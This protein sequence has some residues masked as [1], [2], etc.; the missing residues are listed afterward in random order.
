M[1]DKPTPHIS[2]INWR[3]KTAWPLCPH[4]YYI[5]PSQHCPWCAG[6]DTGGYKE[7]VGT[8]NGWLLKKDTKPCDDCGGPNIAGFG[9]FDGTREE[10]ELCVNNISYCYTCSMA[11]RY[12]T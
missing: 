6:V 2:E 4:G 8:G 9:A 5:T 11:R 1:S 12:N 10:Y 3:G 7:V